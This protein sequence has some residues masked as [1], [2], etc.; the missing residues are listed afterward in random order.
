MVQREE[1]QEAHCGC[2]PE[3][4]GSDHV[5]LVRL[6]PSTC[7]EGSRSWRRRQDEYTIR[8]HAAMGYLELQHVSRYT[9]GIIVGQS[10]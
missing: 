3:V 8:V 6:P 10:S 7:K 1:R 2:G 9:M 4:H 5:M